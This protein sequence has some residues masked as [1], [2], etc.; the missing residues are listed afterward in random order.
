MQKKTADDYQQA[1]RWSGIACAAGRFLP[2]THRARLLA[3]VGLHRFA[4]AELRLLVA[5]M[6]PPAPPPDDT[7]A[8]EWTRTQ[9]ALKRAALQ[10]AHCGVHAGDGGT[11]RYR[12]GDG[13][14]RLLLCAPCCERAMLP[15]YCA[16][17]RAEGRA[18]IA[19]A[20]RCLDAHDDVAI[21]PRELQ[22]LSTRHFLLRHVERHAQP[23][24]PDRLRDLLRRL[25]AGA[26][27]RG[28]GA[29]VQHYG[30][31][32][33]D[34]LLCRLASG[35][36]GRREHDRL[37]EAFQRHTGRAYRSLGHGKLCGGSRIA[38]DNDN[39]TVAQDASCEPSSRR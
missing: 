6:P 23:P 36:G 18:T 38:F 8:S 7:S 9:R 12:Y 2:P 5:P 37:A 28:G 21:T 24:P 29:A 27:D 35:R 14:L 16:A 31:L 30:A 15:P 26:Y 22:W 32:L 34:V 10:C 3:A 25:R 19:A 39:T 33:P 11:P 4:T 20:A 1:S 17:R 13:T